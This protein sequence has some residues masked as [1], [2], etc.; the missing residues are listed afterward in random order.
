MNLKENNRENIELII[1][2]IKEKL[3]VVNGGAMRPE[4]FDTDNYE[5]LVE[6]YEM[7]MNKNL[8]VLVKLTLSS[9]N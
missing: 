6:I 2:N 7:I 5:D 3:Q 8:L 9:L 4:S 1:S